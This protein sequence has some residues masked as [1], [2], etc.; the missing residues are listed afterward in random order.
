MWRSGGRGFI[1]FHRQSLHILQRVVAV[2]LKCHGF[3]AKPFP[4]GRHSEVLSSISCGI[5]CRKGNLE[6]GMETK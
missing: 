3:D 1:D 2:L 4:V 5:P 6:S